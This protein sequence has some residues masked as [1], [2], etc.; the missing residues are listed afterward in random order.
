MYVIPQLLSQVV[1][2]QRTWQINVQAQGHRVCVVV[3]PSFYTFHVAERRPGALTTSMLWCCSKKE[4]K[5]NKKVK[6]ISWVS[7][8]RL[9]TTRSGGG[10]TSINT[11]L[12]K[13]ANNR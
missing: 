8:T 1:P 13:I 3:K 2:S 4:K 10:A 12:A 7:H 6:V 11:A 5:T 9:V